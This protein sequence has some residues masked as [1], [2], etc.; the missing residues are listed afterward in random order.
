MSAVALGPGVTL[1]LAGRRMTP[2]LWCVLVGHWPHL[3]GRAVVEEV[4]RLCAQALAQSGLVIL[5]GH[6]SPE[7]LLHA[8][9]DGSH[10]WRDGAHERR[11]GG[12]LLAGELTTLIRTLNRRA[13][14]GM[15]EK[16]TEAHEGLAA[17]MFC[18]KSRW[19]AW[20]TL[21]PVLTF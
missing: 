3:D 4:Q 10:F 20:R 15:I 16:L 1:P 7:H 5:P 2:C 21:H 13:N 17:R 19:S 8:L 6:C 18:Q 9:A 14:H 11:C 12:V